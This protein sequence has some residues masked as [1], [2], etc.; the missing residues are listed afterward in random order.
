MSS[1][2]SCTRRRMQEGVYEGLGMHLWSCFALC[3]V[4]SQKWLYA[5][6]N[7]RS[8]SCPSRALRVISRE[9]LLQLW[10]T[11]DGNSKW[12]E[13]LL[14]HG[15]VSR[16]NCSEMTTLLPQQTRSC[17][18]PFGLNQWGFWWADFS[19]N[20]WTATSG[21]EVWFW[22]GLGGVKGMRE[23]CKAKTRME[24]CVGT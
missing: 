13:R 6:N 14:A 24:C 2:N 4:T 9:Q 3:H 12:Q 7:W 17:H 21:S 8:V 22:K 5:F 11:G 16:P 20:T 15:I 18:S 23:A 19:E 10:S 1:C